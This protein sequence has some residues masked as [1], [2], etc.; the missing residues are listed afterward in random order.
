MTSETGRGMRGVG[1][2]EVLDLV[3]GEV[4]IECR[5][6]VSEMMRLRR[7]DDGRGNNRIVQHPC[8]RNSSHRE[9]ARFGDALNGFDDRSITLV[10]EPLSERIV[11]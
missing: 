10:L 7:T 4:E 1:R 8:E 3:V 5:N 9:L 2:F 11:V 6:G